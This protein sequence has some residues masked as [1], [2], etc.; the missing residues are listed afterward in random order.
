[1]LR[2]LSF[3]IL[4]FTTSSLNAQNIVPVSMVNWGGTNSFNSQLSQ[5]WYTPNNSVG[6]VGKY[7]KLEIGFR[8]EKKIEQEIQ[9]FI[10][11]R[12]TGINPFDPDQIDV[13]I[14]LTAP[15]G[16][17]INTHGFYYL[18]FFKN[19]FKN[20]W[21][22]DTTSF[23]FR[24]RFAPNQVGTWKGE[25]TAVTRGFDT[26]NSS[27]SFNCVE[28]GHK[29]VLKTSKT[30]TLA[31]RY[32]FESETGDVFIPIGHNISTRGKD[33]TLL[34]NE[35]HKKW[36]NELSDNGGNFFRMELPPGGALPDWPTWPYDST[37]YKSCYDYSSKLDKMYGFDEVFE[38]AELK[39][40][41]FIMM[42]HHVEAGHGESWDSW[43]SNPY[44]LAFNLTSSEA[45]FSDPKI[46]SLQRNTL[47]YIMARWGY[48][49]SFAFYSYQE[50]DIWTSQIGLENENSFELMGNWIKEMK[51]YAKKDL[52]FLSDMYTFPFTSNFSSSKLTKNARS[53][54]KIMIEESDIIGLHAYH[55]EK[56]Q[57]YKTRYNYV[58]DL[59]KGWKNTK[60]LIL[61]EVGLQMP[62]IYCCTDVDF[63]NTVWSTSLMGSMGM[64][65]HW[66]W[67]RG[68]HDKEYY[69]MY[70]NVYAFYKDE[71]LRDG[72]YLQQRWKN[73]NSSK[74]KKATLE[75]FALRSE[76]KERVLG[77]IHNATFYWRNLNEPCIQ[78]LLDSGKVENPCE[79]QDKSPALGSRVISFYNYSN[80][81]FEDAYS[82]KEGAQE[83][84]DRPIFK[85]KGLKRNFNQLYNPWAKK[86]WYKISY[87]VTHGE[88]DSTPI[89][90]MVIST[91][92]LGKLKPRVPELTKENP[93]YSYK[94]E[95]EGLEKRAMAKF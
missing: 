27:F 88:V 74:M 26:A 65:L 60:P 1:M 20:M 93:D 56:A 81:N 3:I 16:K 63:H 51:A 34:K 36:I 87:Y 44:K 82:N 8:L 19:P 78:Q 45:Y 38:L 30:G 13:S 23:K 6:E 18:P 83:V 53:R 50:I 14:K 55:N 37:S 76:N 21:I 52:Y 57:N 95:Y 58:D 91:N 47:Q 2:R 84:I 31:D 92:I 64:G 25:V 59:L 79:L 29:G 39:E 54:A 70:N 5:V 49:P 69:K 7:N 72:K 33:V 46:L 90:T 35:L 10:T 86:H 15:D 17:Q 62:D 9:S 67:D 61:D 73:D 71:N 89:E 32:L 12:S 42:R 24:L 68:I 75:N 41:Y 43:S 77:W 66:N 28:S 22:S 80:P 4:V 94:I 40:V 11:K 85:V 48:S